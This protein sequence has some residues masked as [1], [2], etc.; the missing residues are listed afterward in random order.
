MFLWVSIVVLYRHLFNHYR[1]AAPV[2]LCVIASLVDVASVTLCVRQSKA[3]TSL[4]LLAALPVTCFNLSHFCQVLVLVA[5]SSLWCLSNVRSLWREG[6]NVPN[7]SGHH[8][9]VLNKRLER[10]KHLF[11]CTLSLSICQ[12]KN[13]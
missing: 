4:A 11:H 2:L 13:P 3:Q 10:R 7:G 9:Y 12:K 1:A 8:Y 6:G 5:R